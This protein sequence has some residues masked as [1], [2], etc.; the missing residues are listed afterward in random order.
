MSK[1][2]LDQLS[3]LHGKICEWGMAKLEEEEPIQ[4]MTEQGPV[5][6]GM[7]KAAKASDIAALTKFLADNKVSADISS[8]A[9]LQALEEKLRKKPK[10]SAQVLPMPTVESQRER[11]YGNE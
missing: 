3:D 11:R 2:T 4:A 6:V 10:H 9:G 7:R 8:N 5:T 1:A